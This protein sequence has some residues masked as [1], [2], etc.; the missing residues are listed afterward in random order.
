[1]PCLGVVDRDDATLAQTRPRDHTSSGAGYRH[2]LD[3]IL[4]TYSRQWSRQQ[5]DVTPAVARARVTTPADDGYDEDEVV[6]DVIADVDSGSADNSTSTDGLLEGHDV[7][8]VYGSQYV[9]KPQPLPN[10]RPVAQ[11]G[12]GKPFDANR[13][14]SMRLYKQNDDISGDSSSS[15]VASGDHSFASLDDTESLL[16]DR[17]TKVQPSSQTALRQ[18]MVTKGRQSYQP[19]SR[20]ITTL[21]LS[22]LLDDDDT[23]DNYMLPTNTSTDTSLLCYDVKKGGKGDDGDDKSDS[24]VSDS[25]LD[26]DDDKHSSMT[27]STVVSNMVDLGRYSNPVKPQTE[28]VAYPV[29][30]SRNGGSAAKRSSPQRPVATPKPQPA[31]VTDDSVLEGQAL[32]ARYAPSPLTDPIEKIIEVYNYLNVQRLI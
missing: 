2:D 5:A 26:D 3:A 12:Y 23:R 27:A 32:V 21:D 10:R 8:A 1:M 16:S 31:P 7:I 13:Y 30:G 22:S 18:P 28:I 9:N 29:A 6:D 15:D 14:S 11:Q 17:Q 25:T 20:P 4:N 19:N 24:G